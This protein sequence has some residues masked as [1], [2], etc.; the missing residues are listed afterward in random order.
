MRKTRD[1]ASFRQWSAIWSYCNN[2]SKEHSLSILV[3]Y[4]SVALNVLTLRSLV[5][6]APEQENM[7][8][9]SYKLMDMSKRASKMNLTRLTVHFVVNPTVALRDAYGP[10]LLL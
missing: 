1:E 2:E 7:G 6:L 3:S 9:R 4:M 5:Q 8:F 10:P